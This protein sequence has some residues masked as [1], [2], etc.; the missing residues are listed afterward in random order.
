MDIFCIATRRHSL[1]HASCERQ[2]RAIPTPA[3]RRRP[4]NGVTL[5]AAID[6]GEYKR[7][8]IGLLAGLQVQASFMPRHLP[9]SLFANE[10]VDAVA[11]LS[12]E[13]RAPIFQAVNHDGAIAADL[14]VNDLR[15]TLE[16][17]KPMLLDQPEGSLR[18]GF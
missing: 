15:F 17:G 14:F 7:L 16:M 18:R 3:E 4:E 9:L 12:G 11:D 10:K 2:A 13:N 8:R 5:R 6:V 1:P